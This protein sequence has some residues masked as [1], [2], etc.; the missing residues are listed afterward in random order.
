M[1]YLFLLLVEASRVAARVAVD[2]TQVCG[3]LAVAVVCHPEI[4]TVYFAA[5]WRSR[6]NST[7][8]AGAYRTVP[9]A[10]VDISYVF[11]LILGDGCP[12]YMT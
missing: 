3:N 12:V 9:W 4:A 10:S 5:F 6:K 2:T 8:F 1:L 7:R 11:I